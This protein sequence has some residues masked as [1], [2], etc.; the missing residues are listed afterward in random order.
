MKTQNRNP[1]LAATL[2][3]SLFAFAGCATVGAA[4]GTPTPT[5]ANST[6]GLWDRLTF[7]FTG[8]SPRTNAHDLPVVADEP[9]A[10]AAVAN[11]MPPAPAERVV[12]GEAANPYAL[13]RAIAAP[14]LPRVS[15]SRLSESA[16][17]RVLYFPGESNGTYAVE[18]G[19]EVIRVRD[20]RLSSDPFSPVSW[21]GGQLTGNRD[22]GEAP[23]DARAYVAPSSNAGSIMARVN[24]PRRDGTNIQ[25]Q[26]GFYRSNGYQAARARIGSPAVERTGLV[27]P[28]GLPGTDDASYQAALGALD[29]RA[30]EILVYFHEFGFGGF[31]PDASPETRSITLGGSR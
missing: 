21:A 28:L 2:A 24:T 18:A 6:P 22:P 12:G 13:S 7:L 30:G 3:C 10:F 25:E 20:E 23:P 4:A 16:D 11:R 29:H 14:A 5:A 1:I 26:P 19:R 27:R 31:V 8:V 17:Y 9:K 15:A